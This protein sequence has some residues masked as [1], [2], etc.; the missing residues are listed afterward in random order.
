MALASF[1]RS[2]NTLSRAYLEKITGLVTGSDGMLNLGL[3]KFLKEQGFMGEGIVDKRMWVVK[4]H[5]PG[6][7]TKNKFLA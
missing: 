2:G 5:Y 1:A 7:V 4:T 3:V 6:N